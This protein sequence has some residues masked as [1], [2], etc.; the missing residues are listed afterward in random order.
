[1]N[2][3]Q[4]THAPTAPTF[5]AEVRAGA[6][7]VALHDV[8]AHPR[9]NLE[10]EFQVDQHTWRD[11]RKGSPR[12]GL[13]RQVRA[14]GVG[15]NLERGKANAADGDAVAFLQFLRQLRRLNSNAVIPSTFNEAD[16]G[17]NFFDQTSKHNDDLG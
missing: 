6:V 11:P 1:M 4:A 9:V 12:P 15:C 2:L 13:F 16:D 8:A 10:G 17:S 3:S 5:G 14:K 7:D